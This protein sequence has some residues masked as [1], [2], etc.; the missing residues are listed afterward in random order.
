MHDFRKSARA[1]KA[2]HLAGVAAISIIAV[3]TAGGAADAQPEPPAR[4]AEDTQSFRIEAQPLAAALIAVARQADLL[5]VA[6]RELVEGKTAPALEGRFT[7]TEALA[8]L[9]EGSGI[10]FEITSDRRLI[11]RAKDAGAARANENPGHVEGAIA[12]VRTAQATEQRSSPEP[13]STF[14]EDEKPNEL[15]EIVVTGSYIR[16]AE[17]VGSKLI[18]LD[19]EAIDR[20]GF[21]TVQDVIQTLPQNFGGGPNAITASLQSGINESNLAARSLGASI[22]LRGLGS[23]ATLTILNSRRIAAGG[24]GAFVDISTIPLSAVERIEV[25][26]DGASAIYGTDAIAGVANIILRRDYDGAETRARVG[27][28]TDGGQQEYVASQL[29]GRTWRTGN[30]LLSYEYRRSDALPSAARDFAASSDLRPFG[31]EDFRSQL[32][33][34]GNILADGQSFAIPSGQNGMALTPDDLLE[35]TVNLQN[36]RLGTSLFPLQKRHSVF[37]SVHQNLTDWLTLSAEVLYSNRYFKSRQP[38]QELSLTVPD[39]NPFFVDPIGGLSSIQVQYNFIDDFGPGTNTGRTES[40]AATAGVS[41]D[42]F[43]Q[44]QAELFGTVSQSSEDRTLAGLANRPALAQALADPN[45]ATAFNPFGDGSNTAPATLAGI[46]GFR[47]VDGDFKLRSIDFKIDGPLLR[48]PAGEVKLA[49]GTHYREERAATNTVDFEFAAKPEASLLSDFDRRIIAV[50]GELLLPVVAEGQR[51]PGFKRLELS[52]AVRIEDYDD[53][54]T[55]GNPRVGAVWSPV[56][57]LEVRGTY[58]TSFRAPRLNDLDTRFNQNIFFPLPDPRSP[59]GTS[60]T[61][62]RAGNDPD[63]KPEHATAWTIGADLRPRALPD[64]SL[65][66]TFFRTKFKG[67]I[68]RADDVFGILPNEDIF[69]PLITRN[70]DLATA[71][72]LLDDP[73]LLNLVGSTDPNDVDAIVNI[74]VT[75]LGV[76][77][78]RGLD[79]T[80]AYDVVTPIGKFGLQLN[81]GILADFKEAVTATAPLVDRVDTIDRPV[82]WRMRSR[83]SWSR[84]GLSVTAF[85][86]YVDNYT[87]DN[88]DPAEPISD[89]LTAD[90][91][92][93]FRTE[94]RPSRRWLQGLAFSVSVLNLTDKDPPFVKNPRGFGFDPEQASPQGRFLAFEVRKQW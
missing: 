30:A 44:W 10:A 77:L 46:K 14:E 21:S 6:P 8:R 59:T 52:A 74:L 54:G 55:T 63:L 31:G 40:L 42:I 15:K 27:T 38:G 11:L 88:V 45:P 93:S 49:V 70:P 66:A 64:F 1:G 81:A 20:T 83:L 13:D 36:D 12:P 90:L 2:T 75:N 43:S 65:S 48:L 58:G 4:I 5:L 80:A 19:R 33:N 78:V 84:H 32:G 29:F 56:S 25:L 73:A 17:P 85:L 69:A 53:V 62:L 76:T 67:R 68:G 60:N 91:T 39:T 22:N 92:L 9:L 82:D 3:L 35:G 50:F 23:T 61:I 71:T 41:V 94:D 72:A 89:W 18:E 51:I 24:Q 57:G 86:N 79:V 34:P 28:V 7:T 37:A 26:S 47:S 87:N 16:G